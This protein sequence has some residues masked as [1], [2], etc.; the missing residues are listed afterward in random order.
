VLAALNNG[1]MALLGPVLIARERQK[2][3]IWNYQTASLR[4]WVNKVKRRTGPV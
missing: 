1:D 3:L 4:N 2:E